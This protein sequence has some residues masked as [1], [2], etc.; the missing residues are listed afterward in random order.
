MHPSAQSPKPQTVATDSLQAN[1]H[2]PRMLFD[3]E[4]MRSLR[5][6]ISKVGILVPITVY[7]GTKDQKF[8]ILDGQRRWICANELCL[9]HVPINQ[10]TEPSTVENIVT[11]FQIHK[12]RKDWELMPTAL[13]VEVLMKELDEKRDKPLADLTGLNVAVV[14]RCKKLL[15][16]SK[17]YRE[18]ML[19]VEPTD[20]IKA[21]FFIELYSVLYDQTLAIRS[22]EK[23]DLVT[24]VMLDKYLHK[25]SGFKSITDFRKIK[26]YIS[27]AKNAGKSKEIKDRFYKLLNSDDFLISDLEIDT[28]RVHRE[29]NNFTRLADQLAN[30]LKVI[31][32]DEFLAEEPFWKSIEK[33]I[34]VLQ[35]KLNDADRRPS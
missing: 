29:A 2:N 31:E 1:P 34:V 33:L 26:S 9:Q 8:T 30:S 10:V 18:M 24:D 21:D 12:L 4:P 13:K 5:E 15:R 16:F 28:A 22:Q 23:R 35:R 25:K 32:T 6:S 27:V 20:R 7:K 3:K 19:F 14:V 17:R 11:M